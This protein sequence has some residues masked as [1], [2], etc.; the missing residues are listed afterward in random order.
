M[1]GLLRGIRSFLLLASGLVVAGVHAA[2]PPAGEAQ[3]V[4]PRIATARLLTSRDVGRDAYKSLFFYRQR[5][6]AEVVLA[7]P[8]V[9]RIARGWIAS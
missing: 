8:E 1:G 2:S 3:A 6:A 4:S 9:N 5:R 7:H